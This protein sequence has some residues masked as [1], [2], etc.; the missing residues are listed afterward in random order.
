MQ[1]RPRTLHS[2]HPGLAPMS[3]MASAPDVAVQNAGWVPYPTMQQYAASENAYR[4][5]LAGA[6]AE[7]G[8]PPVRQPPTM[9]AAMQR[10]D[11]TPE[12]RRKM[13]TALAP[14]PVLEKRHKITFSSDARR[15]PLTTGTSDFTVDIARDVLPTRAHGFEVVG[16]SLPASEWTLAPGELALP[17]RHGW[18]ASPGT[19]AYRIGVRALNVEASPLILS[20]SSSSSS[21][22]SSSLPLFGAP[23]ELVLEQPL[24]A[25]PIVAVRTDPEFPGYLR[26]TLARRVGTALAA[27]AE[28]APGAVWL[29]LGNL[30]H[31]FPTTSPDLPAYLPLRKEHILEV[32]HAAYVD[33][34]PS[35]PLAAEDPLGVLSGPVAIAL[36]PE[37]PHVLCVNLAQAAGIT[38][39]P[40]EGAALRE[41]DAL[42]ALG[43]LVVLPAESAEN[44]ARRMSAQLRALIEHRRYY[45]QQMMM[46]SPLPLRSGA[47]RW[48]EEPY[49]L[50]TRPSPSPSHVHRFALALQW[51][52]GDRDEDVR[53]RLAADGPS[54]VDPELCPLVLLSGDA[55]WIRRTQLPALASLHGLDAA[56]H[57]AEPDAL[58]VISTSPPEW[59]YPTGAPLLPPLADGASSADAYFRALQAPAA[60]ILFGPSAGQAAPTPS[61]WD[62]PVR[63]SDGMLYRVTLP[64]GEYDPDALARL[65]TRAIRGLPAL[66]PLRIEVQPVRA[67]PLRVVGFRFASAAGQVFS[68]A[69]DL[70]DP[71]AVDPA[72]FGFRKIAETGR[73]AYAP[74]PDLAA[75]PT[76]A[77]PRTDLGTSVP[78]PPPTVP[79][80][81]ALAHSRRTHLIHQAKPT[82]RVIEAGDAD[83]PAPL[84]M[85]LTTQRAALYHHLQHIRLTARV[86]AQALLFGSAGVGSPEAETI[87]Q[88]SGGGAYSAAELLLPSAPDPAFPLQG[89]A[90]SFYDPAE[91][92]ALFALLHD[93][94]AGT[95]G[96]AFD[97]LARLLGAL[98]RSYGA[99]EI[100]PP[101][102]MD[103][104]GP[105]RTLLATF[106][107]ASLPSVDALLDQIADGRQL[108]DA[109]NALATL[110][111]RIIQGPILQGLPLHLQPAPLGNL[112]L[113]N[114]GVAA[115]GLAFV[116]SLYRSTTLAGAPTAPPRDVL[117][118]LAALHARLAPPIST[119]GPGDDIVPGYVYLAPA[120]P[121]A[122]GTLAP[123]R[124]VILAA[125]DAGTLFLVEPGVTGANDLVAWGSS[126]VPVR[127]LLETGAGDTLNIY[128][129]GIVVVTHPAGLVPD[130][131]QSSDIVAWRQLP[132]ASAVEITLPHN[133]AS[134]SIAFTWNAGAVTTTL[135]MT[136]SPLTVLAKML[137]IASNYAASADG[138]ALEGVELETADTLEDTSRLCRATFLRTALGIAP[139]AHVVAVELA[140]IALRTA[141]IPM[142]D[143]SGNPIDPLRAL[144]SLARINEHPFSADWAT[145]LPERVRPERVGFAEGE[146]AA[147]VVRGSVFVAALASPND[148][149]R[150]GPPYLLMDVQVNGEAGSAPATAGS[151]V[152]GSSYQYIST[153]GELLS[154]GA[155]T[156]ADR[157]RQVVRCVAYVQV[158]GDASA[159]RLL[160]KQDDRSPVLF[161]TA[162]TLSRVRFRFVRPDGGLYNFAGKKVMVTLRFFTQAETPNAF[163][164]GKE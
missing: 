107:P 22:G 23:R 46:T 71:Q 104:D 61:S 55:E 106:S 44:L 41:G 47:I 113:V 24:V 98:G 151:S 158:G 67:G 111:L 88:I 160:D 79:T 39:E 70:D 31:G 43:R 7:K 59:P 37:D 124:V 101:G 77:F 144:L 105:Y 161:P 8:P 75:V 34:D 97:V 133:L 16:Y 135:A 82:E 57:H 153:Q 156:H 9:L 118:D 103:A 122:A 66:A 78:A 139:H 72:R 18:C 92:R 3:A 36:D 81:L 130:A 150:S 62:L 74:H 142:T 58:T 127:A 93:P 132:D 54:P 52:F 12:A 29:E 15:D 50:G 76:A 162:F 136:D 140:Q 11:L 123:G 53:R 25:N 21:S 68:L 128:A 108:R 154:L 42:G 85:H 14:K 89:L 38:P 28:V 125:S 26:I 120:T 91:I 138:V 99:A 64:S 110:L 49:P 163:D 134:G 119:P 109:V 87:A 83:P 63:A 157:D 17:W 148:V 100:T 95:V 112:A 56:H 51:T 102:T 1:S 96:S 35:A 141:P 143:P 129:G 114:G 94:I 131:V 32:V 27:L 13:L 145:D 116:L 147:P 115:S 121:S 5:A 33:G 152:P 164:L 159:L 86:P 126:S 80:L 6:D 20:P 30:S 90:P 84:L 155:S 60:A 4:A 45:E 65:I 73:T 137:L 19:R 48:I 40:G 2:V 117:V 69:W 10:T 149:D 146:Y